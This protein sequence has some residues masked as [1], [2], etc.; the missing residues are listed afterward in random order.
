MG[1]RIAGLVDR[2][3]ASNLDCACGASP[4]CLFTAPRVE[5]VPIARASGR[6]H[7]SASP[8]EIRNFAIS[9]MQWLVDLM[10]R[11]RTEFVIDSSATEVLVEIYLAEI[12]G[13]PLS[14]TA[15]SLCGGHKQTTGLRCVT[16]LEEH[17]LIVRLPDSNDRRRSFVIMNH[18]ARRRLIALMGEAVD[19]R[20]KHPPGTW[21]PTLAKV[22]GK[23]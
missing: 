19:C 23:S 20:I 9:S 10:S 13:R 15:A 3:A 4:E 14:V 17:R 1:C 21:S 18:N 8:T 2:A 12:S 11:L 6:G 5:R 7:G 22:R 16:M